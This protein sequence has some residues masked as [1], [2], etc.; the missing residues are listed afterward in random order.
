[1]P[2]DSGQHFDQL[3][4]E[5]QSG[6]SGIDVIGGDVIWPAQFAANGYIA[7]LSDRFPESERRAFLP[8]TIEANTYEGAI[9]GVPWYTDAGMLYYRLD[10]WRGPATP[11]PP[12]PGTSSRSRRGR[13]K[14][15]RHALRFR[16]PGG[17]LRGRRRQRPGVHL[18]LG[19]GRPGKGTGSS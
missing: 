12:P 18:D 1:M 17:G 2:A 10:L 8:A 6:E 14:K 4:T 7:D 9:Y 11:L 19:R 13:Y 16:L 15:T 3:N 5:F